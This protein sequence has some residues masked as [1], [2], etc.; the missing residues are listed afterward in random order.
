MRTMFNK[1][2]MS[3]N[4]IEM[5]SLPAPDTSS[6]PHSS[7]QSALEGPFGSRARHRRCLEEGQ[8]EEPAADSSETSRSGRSRWPVGLPNLR[9]QAFSDPEKEERYRAASW[10]MSTPLHL[11]FTIGNALHTVY[12][13]ALLFGVPGNPVR[14]SSLQYALVF[15]ITV[16]T[17]IAL[18][19]MSF[20]RPYR[21]LETRILWNALLA[22]TSIMVAVT[23]TVRSLFCFFGTE[24][25]KTCLASSR[26]N[27]VNLPVYSSLGLLLVLIIAHGNRMVMFI[28][29]LVLLVLLILNAAFPENGSIPA[30]F[31]VVFYIGSF[32]FGILV[33]TFAERNE[34]VLFDANEQ[35][36]KEIQERKVAEEKAAEAERNAE[37]FNRTIW[38]EIRVPLNVVIQSEGLLESDDDFQRS[39]SPEVLEN[40]ARIHS[41]LNSIQVIL[42]DVLDI[43][44]FSEG[45]YVVNY[46]ALDY[47]AIAKDTLWS[48]APAFKE[49]NLTFLNDSDGRVDALRY[50]VI[51]DPIRLRQLVWNFVSNAIKFT[52][53]YGHIT[54]R[55]RAL[56]EDISSLAP[57]DRFDI[58]TEVEDDG[59]GIAEE[60][61][62][63]L[64]TD[65]TQ[66]DPGRLQA[67]KGSGLG[68]SICKNI[69]NAL[70]GR[71]GVRSSLG[72]GSTFWFILPFEVSAEGK[73]ETPG[74][75]MD[76]SD[77]A[78]IG[79][80][81]RVLVTD[82]DVLTATVMR[83][84]LKR[85]GYEVDVAVNGE[86]CLQ[87]L[88]SAHYDVLFIDNMMP[89]MNGY[90]AILKLR[91][92]GNDIPIISLSGGT[93]DDMKERLKK[94]GVHEILMKPSN[95]Q[96]IANALKRAMTKP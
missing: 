92:E 74:L 81:L 45:R 51:S 78:T 66:I 68:L 76:S 17:S 7:N 95:M 73:S 30:W 10:R 39:A 8:A 46:Q 12:I 41:G 36:R 34:R 63:K 24:P 27:T 89:V 29:F 96:T 43:K 53:P 9:S 33:S 58:L 54:F 75:S 37:R 13:C 52:P 86:D 82:D 60:D 42:N 44:R 57:G 55:T 62:V 59:V 2:D 47:H 84:L 88:A 93:D 38:H 71:Y 87:K 4:I 6:Q 28:P 70:G 18:L 16:P 64:F 3:D 1:E 77:K 83:K 61:Q 69:I 79:P 23:I 65:F 19:A 94:L 91:G 25:A 49:K 20:V 32:F 14:P 50:K 90:D 72:K 15:G 40:M 5:A 35:L 80:T 21:W 31:G 56:R 48:F 26:P 22:V 67:G 85:L 11:S